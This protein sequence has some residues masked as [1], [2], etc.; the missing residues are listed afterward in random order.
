MSISVCGKHEI[1]LSGIKSCDICSL[2]SQ[3]QAAQE[4][5]T[6]E[7]CIADENY[8]QRKQ[9][10]K[11]ADELANAL[12]DFIYGRIDDDMAIKALQTYEKARV[13]K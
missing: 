7:K 3:L 8:R 12:D 10:E 5:W 1:D 9:V 11:A 13:G 2:E 4:M 6:S